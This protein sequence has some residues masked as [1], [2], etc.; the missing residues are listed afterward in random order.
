MN[1]S[2][3]LSSPYGL[4]SLFYW[5]H[6]FSHVSKEPPSLLCSVF[7]FPGSVHIQGCSYFPCLVLQH[8]FRELLSSLLA[9]PDKKLHHHNQLLLARGRAEPPG[10]RSCSSPQ[11][12]N[13][14]HR[15]VKPQALPRAPQ[16]VSVRGLRKRGNFLH[17]HDQILQ[18]WGRWKFKSFPL[19]SYHLPEAC[20]FLPWRLPLTSHFL[21]RLSLLLSV[22]YNLPLW[23]ITFRFLQLHPKLF[24]A[25]A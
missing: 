21:K 15:D 1:L 9:L 20:L 5:S 2:S 16:A 13:P 23:L 17:S 14:S 24:K 7:L 6:S 25:R 18:H 22:P 4:L 10:L 3:E 11:L 19:A 12:R 8:F